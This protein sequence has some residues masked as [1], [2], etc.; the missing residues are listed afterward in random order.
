MSQAKSLAI[1]VGLGRSG[2]AAVKLLM[3]QGY[4]VWGT[5]SASRDKLSPEVSALGIPIVAGTHDGVPFEDAS[6]VVVSPGVPHFPSLER[7]QAKG[8]EVISEL[9]LGFRHVTVPVLAVGGTN[10]KSTVTTLCAQMLKEAGLRAF[11]GGNLGIPLSEAVGQD[12]DVL[13]VEV[14]S[15]QLERVTT[16][17]PKVSVLLNVSDDHLDR[18]PSFQ[19]YADAKGQAFRLQDSGD[20]AVIPSSD[21]ACSEQARRGNAFVVTFGASGDYVVEPRRVVEAS[22]GRAFTLESSRLFGLHNV[23]NVAACIAAVRPFGVGNDA[24]ER[25]IAQFQPL[26][27]R[28]AFVR[29]LDEVTFYDDS[30]GTNVGASVTALRGLKEDFGV[31]IA[32]GRDKLGAYEP[33]VQALREKGR[34]L[35][36]IG[37]AAECIAKETGDAVPVVRAKTM[38]QAVKVAYELARPGDAVLLSPACASFDMFKSYADRGD[39]FVAA[40]QAL[41][42]KSKGTGVS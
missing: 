31:L 2:I 11:A 42:S 41:D 17:K 20:V 40:V 15:F 6:L 33:L 13:V 3:S 34:A 21:L 22:S 12:F 28:M 26:A 14:S 4:Q 10:G 37:E 16:F 35:V 25:A 18:Y 5:D 36:V 24:I 27:H 32:G 8:A 9:E 7:A 38:V 39:Q 19:A 23:A 30:K 29:E 1:V